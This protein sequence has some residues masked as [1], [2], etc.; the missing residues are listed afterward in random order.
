[1][2]IPQSKE[3]HR[4]KLLLGRQRSSRGG[5]INL[6]GDKESDSQRQLPSQASLKLVKSAMKH[7]IPRYLTSAF[8]VFHHSHSR[9]EK[10]F[11]SWNSFTNRI[12]SLYS[13][14][15]SPERQ[16]RED[17]DSKIS[18]TGCI[19]NH[20]LLVP[21]FLPKA[22]LKFNPIQLGWHRLQMTMVTLFL[23]YIIS[24]WRLGIT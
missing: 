12:L 2:D 16:S 20:R 13:G 18:K 6:D 17:R 7:N 23:D 10:R 19:W 22:K 5:E 24:K 3:S 11:R 14:V 21:T 4:E 1:M 9:H 15:W 8:Q